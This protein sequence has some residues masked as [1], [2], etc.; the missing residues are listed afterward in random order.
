[1]VAHFF[2]DITHFDSSFFHTVHHLIWRPGFLSNEYMRGRRASY[3]HPIRMYVFSS[4]IFFLLFFSVFKKDQIT[5]SAKTLSDSERTA[6]IETLETRISKDSTDSILKNRLLLARDF[7]SPLYARDTAVAPKKPEGLKFS[8]SK[9]SYESFAE[10]DS[11]QR[12]LPE[13]ER[14]G[15]FARRAI[16]KIFDIQT[17]FRDNP[18]EA[19][20]KLM[21]SAFH[22]LPYMLFISLPLF[23]LILYFVY[24]RSR[25]RFYF[26]DHGVFTIH[27]YVFSFIM[28]LV[29]F[30]MD[31]LYQ[32]TK[33]EVF[34]WIE[35]LLTLGLLFY[36]Y[37]AMRNFYGQRRG[38]TLLKF[39][40]VT[41]F[42]LL[43]ML[44]LFA[45]IMFVSAATL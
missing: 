30:A 19:A 17:R 16:R 37:K 15:W 1:M 40:L 28:L 45:G 36:L 25:K 39:I 9:G 4:A 5:I 38:K 13:K 44:I 2:Y 7:Q 11:V 23:S 22:R 34:Q 35:G 42:S 14:D 20:E 43:M 32:F 31:S 3:L 18:E 41:I 21:K 33:L 12:A 26:A 10:Y 24:I 29:A 8:F 6:Y 27:L